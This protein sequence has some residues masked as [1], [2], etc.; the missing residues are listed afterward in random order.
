LTT[1]RT[2]GLAASVKSRWISPPFLPSDR[3]PGQLDPTPSHSLLTLALNLSGAGGG[4]GGAGGA[5]GGT[6]L[7]PHTK[8][9]VL[10]LLAFA[11]S[12]DSSTPSA[13]AS[14]RVRRTKEAI[15]SAVRHPQLVLTW[16]RQLAVG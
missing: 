3:P 7:R 15:E 12:A 8:A 4:G 9:I 13:L 14:D 1:V 11:A 6:A 2:P 5:A 10:E 16:S